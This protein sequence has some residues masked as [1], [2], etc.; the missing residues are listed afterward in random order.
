[1]TK[2]SVIFM[3]RVYPP[4]RGATGRVLRDLAQAMARDGWAV[5]VV[6]TGVEASDDMDG[7]VRVIRLKSR[8]SARNVLSYSAVWVRL[9][10]AALRAPRA[11][12]VVTMTDPPLLVLAGHVLSR[13]RKSK[14]IHWCQDLYPDLFPSVGLHLPDFLM[15]GL[16]AVS[17]YALRRCDKIVVIGRCMA[18][19]LTK[20][21]LDPKRIAV[22]PNW[23][24]RELADAAGEAMFRDEGAPKFRV[25]YAGTIG[26]A[27]PV[28]TILD[29]ATILSQT[30]PEI[31]FVFVGE[32]TGH[33]RLAQ[34]RGKR[35][36][37]NVRLLPR[38]P[39][40]RLRALMESGDVHVMSMKH[41]AA[42]LLVP[43]K[44]YSAL[45][46]GRPCVLVGPMNSEVAKVISDFHAGAVVAQGE[47]ETLAQT[48][49]TLRMDGQAWYDAQQGSAQAGRIFVPAESMN[50]WIKRAR[51]V[52]GR[53]HAPKSQG[54][55]SA[56]AQGK[57]KAQVQPQ[58]PTQATE[59][60]ARYE[61]VNVDHA[62]E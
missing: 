17:R 29:A 55:G 19:Q 7:P 13:V 20:M 6:T 60:P 43:S 40:K 32:G 53:P 35:G 2:P 25:L 56:K 16:S 52:V 10:W 59:Q 62:A 31:E 28:H 57:G 49:L 48:I 21:E 5:T 27:H 37:E 45:A 58:A 18:R 51:D 22:I 14:H 4:S 50:A 3:S 9:L 38:Q 54:K 44:L 24:D 11:D 36:L 15:E 1:M 30:N 12:L 42:G 33:E 8:M 46:V 23:P 47:P 39:Y 61:S 34:E 41:D 26:R